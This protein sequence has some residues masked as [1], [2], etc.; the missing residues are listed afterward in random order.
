MNREK[1]KEAS[2]F[3]MYDPVECFKIVRLTIVVRLC[4]LKS[5]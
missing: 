3:C 4:Y 1:E 2:L 5:F